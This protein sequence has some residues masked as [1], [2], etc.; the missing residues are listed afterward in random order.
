[1][2][3]AKYLTVIDALCAGEF[4]ADDG[5]SAPDGTAAGDRT[6]ALET[7]RGTSAGDASVRERALADLHACREA[8]AERLHE[9]W[10]RQQPWGQQTVR[11]RLARGEEIPE[12]WAVLSLLT[13]ELD[14]WQLTGTAR[15]LAIGLADRDDADEIRLLAT[16]TQTPPP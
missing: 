9:R 5:R 6:V 7:S 11:L 8:I 15:W 1:M 14:V 12:P 10:G 16:V 13:D 2:D 4:P 3:I